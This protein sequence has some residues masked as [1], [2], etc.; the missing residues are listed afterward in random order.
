VDIA[1]IQKPTGPIEVDPVGLLLTGK[2]RW[3]SQ[4][5]AGDGI[6]N[7]YMPHHKELMKK[8]ETHIKSR[9]IRFE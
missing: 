2:L 5:R 9:W 8:I 4:A 1:S 6:L 3:T 7:Q